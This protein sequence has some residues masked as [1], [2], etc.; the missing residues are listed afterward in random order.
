M[1]AHRRT[2]KAHRTAPWI[3]VG[4]VAALPALHA[5]ERAPA[6]L[7][8]ERRV[9]LEPGRLE[10]DLA[11]IRIWTPSETLLPLDPLNPLNPLNYEVAQAAVAPQNIDRPPTFRFEIAA[12]P[13]VAALREFEQLTGVAVRV[14]DALV[15]GLT[16]DGVR[17]L[18]TATQALDRLLAG[19]SLSHTFVDSLTASI[20]LR[21]DAAA[22]DVTAAAAKVP[23]AKYTAALTETPQTIQ[24]IPRALI[25]EQGATTLSDALRNVPG[26]T[27]QAGEGGGAS[28]TSGDMFNMRGF[29]ANNSLFV[30]GVRDDGLIA[31][32][33][34]NLEQI[35]VFSG[36]AG[37]DVGRT[38]AAGYINLTTK[39][40][41][42][43]AL[44][45]GTLSY[46][47][48]DQVRATIDV[49][50]PVRFGAPGTFFGNAA[51]RVNA[52]WQDGGVAG[53]DFA[54][55]DSAAIAP[56][57]AFGLNTSTRATVAAQV[58]RQDNLPDYGLPAAAS[59]VGTLAPGG[60]LAALPV[61][62]STY[63]GSPDV[64]YD[65][66]EQTSATFRLEHDITPS[67]T[68]RNQTRVNDTERRAV[69][70]SIANAA[71]YNPA[72]NLV[73]LSRQANE[74]HNDVVSNQTNVTARPRIGALRHDLSFGLEIA[75][76]SQ[77]AP[78]LTGVGTRAPIDLNH[79]DVFSPVLDMQIAQTG[80]LAEGSTET[81][82][83]Y[84]FDGVDLG[85]RLRVNG[86][87]RIER[88]DTRSHAVAANGAVTDLSG[89]GVLISGKAGLLYRLTDRGNVYLSYGSSL[90]PPGS[91]N[92]QLNA[93]EGNQNNP[94]V[95]PQESTNYEI[96]TKWDLAGGR[97]QAS[98]SVFHTQNKNVIFV[99]D[100]TAVPPI[101]NQDDGQRVTGAAVALIGRLLPRW[102]VNLSLQYLDSELR[103]QNPANNR[104]RLVLAPEVSGSLW[105]TVRVAGDVRI[106]GGVRYTDPVFVNAANTIVVP[107]YAVADALFEA[108]VSR[109]LIVR[110]NVYNL[111]DREF[112]RNINNNGG[113]YNP[114]TPRSF[115]LST[116]VRF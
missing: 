70:S 76:E 102:D 52:L 65:K 53:R 12:G 67:F 60:V 97:L 38:N 90:T 74:R 28:N 9:L 105:T 32:D 101:F 54:Q 10:A 71:A 11:H 41:A 36:P 6:T 26:I 82:A 80:A 44:H 85:R 22:V 31:R 37:A 46:G 92:F 95:D 14:D 89:D 34:F 73:T 19:T 116:A 106:G 47:A 75:R 113:R 79:P 55:R 103:T 107:R 8:G 69:I 59:P 83:A 42:S 93:A 13:L 94:N 45:A 21:V 86:G 15:Q 99:V 1:K 109:Q 88:Y 7:P 3:V 56:S 23:S 111:T 30:D 58:V 33:V 62:Q 2:R 91:A 57:I 68:I 114:G 27:M 66:V 25:D 72:T 18:L 100:A 81:I 115:L 84:L 112:I 49:N 77:F 24:V 96:G 78:T 61:E 50:Q 63:Y 35:E 87:I 17:G 51:V 20:D 104:K 110:L 29:S 98:G 5:A 4:A 16:T 48:A 64:D 39:S 43:E 40:P 108:P